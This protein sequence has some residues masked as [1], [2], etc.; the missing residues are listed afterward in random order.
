[1][2]ST[3]CVQ[4]AVCAACGVQHAVCSMRCAAC[5]VQHAVCSTRCV[6]HAAHCMR[7]AACS[8]QHAVRSMRCAACGVQHAVQCT[9]CG[10]Q[11][12]V[13]SMQ[14]AACTHGDRD[15]MPFTAFVLPLPELDFETTGGSITLLFVQLFT[16]RASTC[17][18]H[19]M[20]GCSFVV[21]SENT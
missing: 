20:G 5:G 18:K 16:S 6:Q 1:M 11:H 8:A 17:A 9:A 13:C 3:W 7:C 15:M 10:A 19:D 12:A 4:H 2:R 21:K 14:C